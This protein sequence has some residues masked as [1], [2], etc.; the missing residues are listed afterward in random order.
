MRTNIYREKILQI[1]HDNHLLSIADICKQI[2]KANYSTVYRNIEQ[3]VSAGVV[4]R[5]VFDKN[6]VLYES[7][8][9]KDSHD[10]FLCMDCGDF[11]SIQ[12]PHTSKAFSDK[13]VIHDILVRGLCK[14][15]NSKN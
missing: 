1:L 13:H 9:Q 11:E 7:V 12:L 14:E 2:A 6:T 8:E 15:C 3:M 10:H 5:I 4:R